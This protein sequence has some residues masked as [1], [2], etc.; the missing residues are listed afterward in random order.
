MEII[1][2]DTG[3]GW[4]VEFTHDVQT[5]ALDYRSDTEEEAAW[6]AERLVECFER[7][8]GKPVSTRK[9]SLHKHGVMQRFL[10]FI[11]QAT[12]KHDEY[13]SDTQIRTIEC[14]K[15][16]KRSWVREYRSLYR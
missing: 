6:M 7:A 14:R 10:L 1:T 12:C 3:D 4:T 16:G 2:Y 9:N 5:F 11:K 8:W 13:D 15:C